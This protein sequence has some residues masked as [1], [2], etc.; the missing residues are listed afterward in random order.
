MVQAL[1]KRSQPKSWC[2]LHH[3]SPIGWCFDV[4]SPCP[5]CS[6][7]LSTL[8]QLFNFFHRSTKA[9]LWHWCQAHSNTTA[10]PST[11]SSTG[12]YLGNPT[13]ND[14]RT[15]MLL[16]PVSSLFAATCRFV[17]TSL[18][19]LQSGTVATV[20]NHLHLQTCS[21][22]ED[23]WMNTLSLSLMQFN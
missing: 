4:S 23:W 21:L 5:F 20:L 2:S 18:K 3:A 1:R 6:R 14:S 8:V 19:I 13:I 12:F 22:S 15:E 16:I 9:A 11:P 7:V 10:T 17:F